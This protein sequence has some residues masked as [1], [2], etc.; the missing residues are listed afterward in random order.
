MC[1]CLRACARS[2]GGARGG[3][4][5]E[6]CCAGACGRPRAAPPLHVLPPPPLCPLAPRPPP[7][8]AGHGR[9]PSWASL[10]PRCTCA[11]TARV[12][13]PLG[14]GRARG[15]TVGAAP[16]PT[17]LLLPLR[18]HTQ[19]WT[20]CAAFVR[21]WARRS[22]CATMSGLAAWAWSPGAW[23]GA[24]PTSSPA[25]ASWRSG[26]RGWGCVGSACG[27]V[28]RQ[29]KHQAP[30]APLPPQRAVRGPA[31]HNRPAPTSHACMQPPRHLRHQ[32]EY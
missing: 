1:A 9:A 26:A 27:A 12:R 32:A 21:T 23:A 29:A 16:R 30:H 19:P 25:T 11:A 13:L 3:P 5:S 4:I 6:G 24:M 22:K 31:Q 15:G 10:R 7:T 14:C 20:W 17:P 8:G 2:V 18:H 28:D